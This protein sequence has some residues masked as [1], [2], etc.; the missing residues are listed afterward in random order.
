MLRILA[1]AALPWVLSACSGL[2]S[3]LA[4]AGPYADEIARLSWWM[5]AGASVITAAVLALTAWAVWGRDRR[6]AWL[7]DHRIIVGGGLILPSIVLLALLVPGLGIGLRQAGDGAADLRIRVVGEQWWWRV[8]YLDR[9]GREI[10]ETANEVRIPAGAMVA[11]ELHTAD[12]IHSFWVPALAG[13]LDMVPGQTNVLRMKADVPGLYR[14]QCAEFC[15]GAHALMA[16]YVVAQAPED[17]DGW[18]ALQRQP[19]R[20]STQQERGRDVF[21]AAGCGACHTVRG[22]AAMGRI[23]PDLTHVGGRAFIAAGTLPTTRT[24]LLAWIVNNQT[25]KPHNRM[26]EFGIF[27]GQDT[28]ALAAWLESLK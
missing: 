3:S 1:A 6:S 25:I 24:N 9:E 28:E 8:I 21:F 12:V 7:A 14:G 10:A 13:K 18:L 23:G 27:N 4:P 11:F 26:P 22:T 15:G 19:A 20:A 5:F 17:F 16:F 2:Q